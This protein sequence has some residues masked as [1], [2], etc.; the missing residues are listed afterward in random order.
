VNAATDVAVNFGGSAVLGTVVTGDDI[1]VNGSG[2][3]AFTSLTSGDFTS[4]MAGGSVTGGA[5]TTG[6]SLNA[7]A[8][9]AFTTTGPI[10][11]GTSA[12]IIGDSITTANAT[13][14]GD[15]VLSAG[16][17][18][19]S[20]SNLAGGTGVQIRGLHSA[21]TG[22]VTATANN[23]HIIVTNGL[24]SGNI[25]AATD[26]IISNTANVVA[27]GAL[28]AGNKVSI[29]NGGAI[30]LASASASDVTIASTA[31]S[32]NVGTV[33]AR[34]ALT[35]NAA[36][37]LTINTA[38]SGSNIALT[39]GTITATALTA[40]NNLTGVANGA[41]NVGTVR[42][43]GGNLNLTAAGTLSA[44]TGGAL[45]NINLTS[46]NGGNI[47][48]GTLSSGS[49]FTGGT[50]GGMPGAG[51]III[52]SDSN[53]TMTGNSSAGRN[54]NVIARNLISVGGIANGAAID[55][56]STD[57]AVNTTTGRIG[58]QGRTTLAQLTNTGTGVT[59]IGGAGVTTGYSLSNAEAQRIFAG[60]IIITA[61]RATT[62]PA[63][64]QTP[65]TLN[66]AAPDVVLDAL[67][68]TGAIGQT[69]A[70]TGNIGATGR[71]RIETP[72]KLRTIGT[73]AISNLATTNRFQINAAQSIEVDAATGSISL[74]GAAGAPSGTIELTAPSVI[75]ASLTAIGDVAA[76]ADGRAINDRLAINDNAI[77]DAGAFS[78][79]TIIVNVSNG[80]FVQNSGIK[81]LSA[82]SFGDRRGITV[83][84]GG[85]AINAASPTT[86]IFVSGR[87]LQTNGSFITGIDF[88]RAQT[89]NGAQIQLS[90]FPSTPFDA[91]STVNGCA[92]ATSA[93]CLVTIDGGSLARDV[94]GQN[95]DEAPS[96]ERN[97]NSGDFV[98]FEFK[99]LDTSA[100]APV[101]DD[102]VTGVGNDDLYALYDARDCND[103]QNLE[104][105]GKGE[106][107]QQEAEPK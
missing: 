27:A 24:T 89:I 80:F 33:T 76:A 10:T 59:T 8:V 90:T 54:L 50:T 93:A 38:T 70:S 26:I 31:S 87:Q 56:K 34:G 41:M 53:A 37:G 35:G 12:T 36:T 67:T 16:Q 99:S 14:G 60:D 73:V 46:T 102:P 44:M 95:D 104:A 81:E 68:L 92:I 9:G 18:A 91:A 22:N 4:I 17:G 23:V 96:N 40:A 98:R 82:L 61:A 62:T 1:M 49:A 21:T 57:I 97:G 30:T 106:T 5:V 19:I 43:A 101:V 79:N 28:S 100:F 11:A 78:A 85:L 25:A 65:T 3:A 75:A 20:T 74:S 86:R 2:N 77:S 48:T 7:T 51:D 47:S 55:L 83:G 66:T 39:G 84:N 13:A 45:G 15:L 94:V 107:K 6:T 69:G 105:C 29:N 63:G 88:L 64:T 71:L 58:E 103:D 52:T 42:A 32:I 72:G